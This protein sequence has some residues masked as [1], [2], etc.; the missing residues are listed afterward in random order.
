M[1][2]HHAERPKT[3]TQDELVINGA[4]AMPSDEF[5][6]EADAGEQDARRE[7]AREATAGATPLIFK[8]GNSGERGAAKRAIDKIDGYR[9]HL[10]EGIKDGLIDPDALT[11]NTHASEVLGDFLVSAGE[12][13]RTLSDFQRS[14]QRVR[15]DV[16]RF[17]SQMELVKKQNPGLAGN[18]IDAWGGEQE[19]KRSAMKV[20]TE[21]G[22]SPHW[23]AMQTDHSELERY[24]GEASAQQHRAVA[25][26][27]RVTAALNAIDAGLPSR[28]K[29]TVEGG[30]VL[31]LTGTIKTVIG[32]AIEKGFDLMEL[33]GGKV[34]SK[35]AELGVDALFG[36]QLRELEAKTKEQEGKQLHG[37]MQ[38]QVN[39]LRAELETWT[40]ARI[41]CQIAQRQIQNL[42]TNMRDS[43]RQFAGAAENRG[44]FAV[45]MISSMYA[46]SDG[47]LS[48]IDLTIAFGDLENDEAKKAADKDRGNI[49]GTSNMVT[50]LLGRGV[51]YYEPIRTYSHGRLS[52]DAAF[53][54]VFIG[55][56][57]LGGTEGGRGVN[58]VVAAALEDLRKMRTV[59]TTTRDRLAG[60]LGFSKAEPMQETP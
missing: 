8:I 39:T 53:R 18:L 16:S 23:T 46:E 35:V 60:A 27:Y 11:Q 22:G 45:G 50:E 24:V 25:A 7:T 54:K 49:N 30:E 5:R 13:G 6:D 56:E 31:A 1:S 57:G 15:L 47:L 17:G 33:P 12:Q 44:E 58:P 26:H 3:A 41:Q 34:A 21:G 42:K 52:Y 37:A 28:D 20:S 4:G 55:T 43:A 48:Q 29:G 51:Q 14:Y 32:F 36:A 9:E 10:I 59:M 38:A 40:A 19:I 2:H